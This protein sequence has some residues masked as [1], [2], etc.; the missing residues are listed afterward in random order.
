MGG[1]DEGIMTTSVSEKKLKSIIKQSV[2]EVLG[3]EFMKLRAFVLPEV[4]REEQK[5]IE[6]HYR[7]PARKR[8]KTYV[9]E[10]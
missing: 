9:L 5:D 7:K 6:K 3:A 4:S 2:K 10:V 8:A 1:Y